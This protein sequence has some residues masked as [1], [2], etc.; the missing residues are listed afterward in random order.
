[1]LNSEFIV[2]EE[3][4]SRRLDI[5]L[6]GKLPGLTRSGIKNLFEEGR[7][8]LNNKQAKPGHKVKANDLIRVSLPEPEPSAL[9]PENIAI[10]VL[11]ED[12]DI[13]IVNKP[14]GLAMHPGAGRAKGTLVNALL[15]RYKSLSTIGG[16]LRPGIVHRL[17]KDTTGVL[18][19][20]RNNESHINLARQF[21]EHS[22]GRRYMALVWGSIPQDQGTIDIAIGR[23]ISHRKKISS[24]TKKSREAQTVFSVIK[25]YPA[26][27][28]M[29]LSP[30][31]GRT[32]QIRVHMAAINHPVVGD[33][34]YCKRKAPG[35]L[36]KNVADKLK[37]V[38]RQLLHAR[39]LGL[40]HPKDNRYLEFSA[41][42]PKDMQEVI[43]TLDAEYSYDKKAC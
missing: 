9:E 26:F 14:A 2:S 43:D 15:G 20:A 32:H 30:Q 11:Y 33:P 17:D 1:M 25:R 4:S 5:F 18:V 3:E 16:P 12:D 37:G 42:P 10:E 19:I 13:I 41:P 29:E 7:V 39:I 35:N 28:L 27:T 38:K 23:D 6:T 22:T 24:R 31:T 36:P 8:L 40:K 21:K 34:L